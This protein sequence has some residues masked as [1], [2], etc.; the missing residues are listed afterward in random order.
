ARRGVDASDAR[1][2]ELVRCGPRKAGAGSGVTIRYIAQIARA[3]PRTSVFAQMVG[4]FELAS[5]DP[6]VVSLNLVQPEDDPTAVRDFNLHMTML[7]FLHRQYPD[8]P[9]ALHAGE[10]VNGLVPPEVLRSHIRDS[11]TNGH[12]RRIGHAT[13]VMN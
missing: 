4:W 10:L 11:I 3:A 13:S 6:R 9:I 1:K 8:V 5:A 12:A 2:M 7:D